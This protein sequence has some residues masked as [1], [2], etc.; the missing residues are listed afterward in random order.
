MHLPK[1][2]ICHCP[3][4]GRKYF[5]W[6]SSPNKNCGNK[7]NTGVFFLMCLKI[8]KSS[9]S[10]SWFEIM[11]FQFSFCRKN[12]AITYI[13]FHITILATDVWY[14]MIEPLFMICKVWLEMMKFWLC[15]SDSVCFV[16]SSSRIARCH[17]TTKFSNLS[18]GVSLSLIRKPTESLGD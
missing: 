9:N 8:P 6:L 2:Y 7:V 13:Q 14:F 1:S 4:E 3:T 11:L 17:S 16:G 5:F 12:I 15:L 10:S 18:L